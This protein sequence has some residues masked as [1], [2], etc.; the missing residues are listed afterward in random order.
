MYIHY[1]YS[2]LELWQG[3]PHQKSVSG[4][5]DENEREKGRKGKRRTSKRR[6]KT[7]RRKRRGKYCLFNNKTIK[8]NM[9]FVITFYIHT[10]YK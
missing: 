4:S 6:K 1:L 10:I 9:H 7:R 3:R 5:P 2:V 8:K